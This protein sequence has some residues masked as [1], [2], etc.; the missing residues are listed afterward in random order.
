MA[1]PDGAPFEVE[2]ASLRQEQG[3]SLKGNL[4]ASVEAKERLS[5]SLL[6]GSDPRLALSSDVH[7]HR[8]H[9][10]FNYSEALLV[11]ARLHQFARVNEFGDLSEASLYKLLHMLDQFPLQ[12]RRIGDILKLLRFVFRDEF[13]MSDEVENLMLH[14]TALHNRTVAQ[15]DDFQQLLCELPSFCRRLLNTLRSLL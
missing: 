3:L 12:R 7:C 14:Y 11:H 5:D 2:P 6:K 4:F 13:V 8:Y 10:A 1:L 9:P 15:A